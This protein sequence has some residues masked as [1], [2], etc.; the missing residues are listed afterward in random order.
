MLWKWNENNFLFVT[1]KLTKMNMFQAI[2]SAL[3][4]ALKTDESAG[5]F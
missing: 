3:D 4:I 1:G 2:N 5:I